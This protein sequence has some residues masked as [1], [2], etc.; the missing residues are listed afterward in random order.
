MRKFMS[1]RQAQRFVTTHAAISNLFNLGRLLVRAEHYRNLR[2]T[3]F[4][5]GVRS[6]A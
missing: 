1:V 2:T 3:A 5:E 6:V 4:A